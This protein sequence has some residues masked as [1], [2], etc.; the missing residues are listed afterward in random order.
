MGLPAATECLCRSLDTWQSYFNHPTGSILGLF[1]CIQPVGQILS[2]P[3]E[4]WFSDKYG[5]RFG[6]FAGAAILLGEQCSLELH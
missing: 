6:M 5:R 2:F 3:V 1:N 4:A